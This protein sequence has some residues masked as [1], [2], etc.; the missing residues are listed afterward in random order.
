MTVGDQFNYHEHEEL[1]VRGK[2][3]ALEM[4]MPGSHLCWHS[5]RGATPSGVEL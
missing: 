3:P 1:H 4:H 5:Q 2:T